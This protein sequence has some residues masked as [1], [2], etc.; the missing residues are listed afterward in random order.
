MD[1]HRLTVDE[2]RRIVVRAALLDAYRPGDVVEV[3]EQLGYVKIDPT[4][5]IVPCEHTVL[6]SRIGEAYEPGH[7]TKAVETDRMLFEFDGAFRPMSLLPAMLPGMR[8]NPLRASAEEWLA[9]NTRFRREV[10]AR[11][12]AEGPLLG[13]KIPD[14]AEVR[15]APDGWYGANQTPIMLELLARKGE[16]AIVGREG[17][18]RRWDLAE[19]VYP[20]DL[21]ELARDD[22][23]E[24]LERRSLQTAGLARPNHHWSGVGKNTGDGAVVEGSRMRFRVDPEAIAALDDDPGGRVA[25]LNPYDSLLFDRRRLEEVFGFTYVLEQFK[26]KS[27][28]RYGYFA[29]PILIGNRFAGML[30]AELDREND[31]LRVNAIHELMRW[32]EEEHDMVRAEIDELAQ[33]LGVAAAGV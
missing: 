11:L 31:V 1:V 18:H 20:C 9:A 8:E 33:W 10:L 29:H 22:A 25:F 12:R 32:D 13:T 17:R 16:I 27:Q 14:T 28:R 21:P 6:W 26:P 24:A 2:A 3:A 7:L 15:V 23:E 4:A 30:D 5:V 19:R